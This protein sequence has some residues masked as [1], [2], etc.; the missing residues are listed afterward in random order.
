MKIS[1]LHSF[2]SVQMGIWTQ[3]GQIPE[4]TVFPF[5]HACMYNLCPW[6]YRA[7]NL[8]ASGT[9]L[10]PGEVVPTGMPVRFR[11]SRGAVWGHLH[12]GTFLELDPVAGIA[13][14]AQIVV[15][16]PDD[17]GPTLGFGTRAVKET[18]ENSGTPAL[19]SPTKR[20]LCPSS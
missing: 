6:I 19:S 1:R 16:L 13:D 18:S 4:A 5:C 12:H 2:L 14:G 8:G 17:C 7:L 11:S 10:V 3:V 9:L 15:C 20:S